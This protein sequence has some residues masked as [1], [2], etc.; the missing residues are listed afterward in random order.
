ME[1][2]AVDQVKKI[3]N[4][5][6]QGFLTEEELV[7]LLSNSLDHPPPEALT[8]SMPANPFVP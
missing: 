5:Y 3:L 7:F 6:S 8:G 4:W 2:P 1:T